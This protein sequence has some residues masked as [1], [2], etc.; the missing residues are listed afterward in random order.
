MDYAN[1]NDDSS[2][3]TGWTGTN[4][5][6]DTTLLVNTPL[7][8]LKLN[9][10]LILEMCYQ[11]KDLVYDFTNNINTS[12][13]YPYWIDKFINNGNIGATDTQINNLK[14][15]WEKYVFLKQ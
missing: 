13:D 4:F 8:Y 5:E 14:I 9:R 6:L 12:S 15:E 11:C 2:Y 1:N 7:T 3:L 10:G